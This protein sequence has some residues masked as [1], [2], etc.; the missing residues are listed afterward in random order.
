[1]YRLINEIILALE[2]KQYCTAL[3]MDI[4]KAFD[5]IN[6]ESLL[7]TIR[8][9]FPEQI[10]QLIKSYLSGRTF[11]IKIRDTYSEVKDIKAGVSQGSVL[12]PILYTLYRANIPTT[13]NSK[14]LTFADNTAILFRYTNPETAVKLLQEHITK[15]EKWLQEKQIKANP[16]KCNHITFTL[17]KQIPPN[18]LL[19]GT[20]ITQTKQVKYLGLHLDTQLT[21]KQHTK[22]I[23]DKIQ[24][25][26]RQMH[27]LTSRKS[28]LSIENKF[29]IYKTIIKP[30]WTYG[31][32]LWWAAAMSH[33]NK[34]ETMQAKILRTIVNVPWYVINE[35][36]RRDLGIPTVKEAISYY[37]ERYKARIA[38]HPNR[39]AAVTFNTL[40][41]ERKLKRKHPAD[42]TKDIT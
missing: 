22:S 15:I 12:G 39:L 19:N 11:V 1:M 20:H 38:T 30:I 37:A 14:I 9:Q 36:I 24:T 26:R 33:I 16:N 35:D 10:Y 34:I 27:W 28:K 40:N 6:H 25:T 32:P 23:I 5:K 17:R 4:E 21:W 2:N 8:K 31:T 13:I 18:I 29:R 3:F 41:M 7:Q 42:L